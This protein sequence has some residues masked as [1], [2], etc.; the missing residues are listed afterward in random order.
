MKTGVYAALLLAFSAQNAAAEVDHH[1][2]EH[3][4]H[5]HE[6]AHLSIEAHVHGIANLTLMAEGDRLEIAVSSPAVN[7]V[8][9]EHKAFSRE[10]NAIVNR[11]ENALKRPESLFEFAGTQC[12][13]SEYHVDVSGLRTEY[14]HQEDEDHDDEHN[15]AHE[16]TQR[17]HDGHH[18]TEATATHSDVTA[19]YVFKCEKLERLHTINVLML[20]QFPAI[21]TLETQWVINGEQGAGKLGQSRHKLSF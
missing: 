12:V 14:D 21:E 13:T 7:I 19:Q 6:E 15:H 5:D 4:H 17:S 16:K 9:F 3:D 2:D 18:A 10:E 8:G 11:V 1:D 20:K